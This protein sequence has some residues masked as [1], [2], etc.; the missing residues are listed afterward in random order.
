MLNPQDLIKTGSED[1]HQMALFQWAALNQERYPEFK[2]L[3]FA[4]PN[5]GVFG[6]DKRTRVIRAM[7]MKAMGMKNGVADIILLVPSGSYHGLVVELKR[8]ETE[9]KTKGRLSE[10]QKEFGEM[11]CKNGYKVVCCYGWEEA[12]GEIEGYMG[13]R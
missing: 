12:V 3:L 4:V 13:D 2:K 6:N 5:S 7:K 8:P 1:E 11:A 9:G 10:D